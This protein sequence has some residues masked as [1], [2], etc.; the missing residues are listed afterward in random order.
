M[1]WIS[2]EKTSVHLALKT[3]RQTE[4]EML[5]YATTSGS[6]ERHFGGNPALCKAIRAA[7]YL[8]R[9]VKTK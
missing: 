3:Y 8:L 1:F 4:T 6:C 7:L 9:L 5:G 2:V